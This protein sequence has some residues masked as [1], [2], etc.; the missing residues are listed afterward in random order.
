M[1]EE[2]PDYETTVIMLAGEVAAL[3]KLVA[4]L[5]LCQSAAD[6]RWIASQ[7]RE[8]TKDL[9]EQ[10]RVTQNDNWRDY[11]AS[12]WNLIDPIIQDMEDRIEEIED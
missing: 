4:S 10:V 5:L 3:R 7:A 12:A 6:S 2:R 8:F 1:A 11:A 9:E